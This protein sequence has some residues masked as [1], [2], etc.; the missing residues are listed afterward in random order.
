MKKYPEVICFLLGLISFIIAVL[1]PYDSLEFIL[2]GLRP[3]GFVTICL[4]P[5]LGIIGFIISIKRKNWIFLCLNVVQ[6][7]AFPLSMLIGNIMFGP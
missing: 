5:L 3:L 6:I 1:I 7:L 2:G 4:N